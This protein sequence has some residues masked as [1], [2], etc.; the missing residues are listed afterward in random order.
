M[1]LSLDMTLTKNEC[2]QKNVGD[3]ILAFLGS[4]GNND[5]ASGKTTGAPG[6]ETGKGGGWRFFRKGG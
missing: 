3:C 1:T 2:N 6:L 4:E 5:V